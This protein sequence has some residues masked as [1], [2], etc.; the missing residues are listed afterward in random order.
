MSRPALLRRGVLDALEDLSAAQ[1]AATDLPCG[2]EIEFM[3]TEMADA[4][5]I[6]PAAERIDGRTLRFQ[7]DTVLY[8]Y[9]TI[10]TL[11]IMATFPLLLRHI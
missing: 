1:L 3:A 7:S 8:A 5:S 10:Q 2:V 11:G 6:S 4:A 9:Q